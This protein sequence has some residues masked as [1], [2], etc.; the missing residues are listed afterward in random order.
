MDHELVGL[1]VEGRRPSGGAPFALIAV[2][3]ALTPLHPSW[4][5]ATAVLGCAALPLLIP[6][7]RPGPSWKLSADGL[8]LIT[9]D[10]QIKQGYGLSRIQELSVTA[11]E[12]LLTVHHKFGTTQIGM[13]PDMGFEPKAFFV[14]ARRLGIELRIVDGDFA[15]DPAEEQDFLDVE[16][17][18]M[19]AVMEPSVPVGDPVPLESTAPGP[20]R[21][22]TAVI[23][24]LFAVL[25]AL[26]TVGTAVAGTP[27]FAAR[28]GAA[29]WV[30]AGTAVLLATRRRLRR[31]TPVRWTISA[32]S[33]NGVPAPT[34]AAVMI[35]PGPAID[36][37]T[38]DPEP[39]LLSAVL[40]DHRLKV[41][42]QLNARGLDEFQLV[43]TL[44]EH[45]YQVITTTPSMPNPSDYGLDGLPD[46]F[47]QV[48]GG[49]LVVTE[50]GL[51]WADMAGDILLKMPVDRIGVIELLTV[52]GNAWLRVYDCDGEEFLA[53]PLKALRIARTDLRDQARA[54]GLPVTDAEYEAYLSAAF[55]GAISTLSD[56]P[57]ALPT[58]EGGPGALLDATPRSRL[59]AYG[60]TAAICELVALAGGYWLT[61]FGP[62]LAWSAPVG[63]LIGLSG[64]WLY[65]R[66]RSQLR[67]SIH[68][69]A[70]VTR[71]G[72]TDWSLR[73]ET[74][75]GVG[76][77]ESYEGMPRLVVWSPGGRVLRRV[78]FAPDLSE[79]RRACE[80]YGLPW[81]PPDSGHPAAAPPEI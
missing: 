22:R 41:L 35:G 47:A 58:P 63:I 67:V 59:W 64:A 52:D 48:P 66:R 30:L 39:S 53:A 1:R 61:G 15:P 73:R 44:D 57:A 16:A 77:D 37:T 10:G 23:G 21:T 24:V 72:K 38:G 13:L 62:F 70:S 65:D 27:S 46:I 50:D 75:G 11:G 45:G 34:I 14:T 3:I 42:A 5:W 7:A 6:G 69:I 49:R 43:H 40:F 32:E 9:R 20:G 19:A 54:A 12:Q 8:Q 28:L 25:A 80:K 60:V 17:S 4:L 79:L 76:I 33:V 18:L 68:G 29:C 71:L 74:V 55:H 56:S 81:G 51:G 26:I 31:T 78:S 2:A 36:P